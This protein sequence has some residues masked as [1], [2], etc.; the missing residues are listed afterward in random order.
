MRDP[1]R[2]AGVLVYD[3]VSEQGTFTP[4]LSDMPNTHHRFATTFGGG[5]I[6]RHSQAR[7]RRADNACRA[8]NAELRF[9]ATATDTSN[10]DFYI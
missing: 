8:T 5:L 6:G 7:T 3:W 10:P 1:R 9:Q 4:K 2:P